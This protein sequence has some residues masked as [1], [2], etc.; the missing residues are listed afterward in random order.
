MT[1]L[2]CGLCG[3]KFDR[4]MRI[5]QGCHGEIEYGSG[6]FKWIYGGLFGGAAY[7]LIFLFNKYLFN[8]NE[9]FSGWVV[10]IAALIGVFTAVNQFKHSYL[11]NKVIPK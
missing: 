5:C 2:T 6:L 11:V 1:K 9:T 3:F 7:G 4:G 8:L 10:I